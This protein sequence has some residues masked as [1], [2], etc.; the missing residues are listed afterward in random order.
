MS[1]PSFPEPPTQIP[2]TSAEEVERI[3]ERL[4]SRKAAWVATDIP[5]RIEYLRS[6]IEGVATVARDWVA[7]G[8]RN[9]GFSPDDVLAGE[10][11]LAGPVTTIR[12]ARLFM[13]ALAANGQPKVPHIERGPDGR[14]I[15]KVFPA[16]LRDRL[17][18][19][20]LSGEI[21]LEPGKEATQGAI[22][23]EKNKGEGKVGLVLGAGN[24]GSIAPMDALTKLFAENE[25]VIV[26]MNPVNAHV[27]PHLERAFKALIDDGFMAIVYGGADVGAQLANHPKVDTLHVTGSDKTYD[28]IVWGRDPAEAARRKAA[29]EPLNTRPF[30]AELGCVTPVLV[31]P[32]D[33]SS[34]DLDFHARNIVGMVT[35]NASFNCNAAKVMVLDASWP[36]R[37][38][39]IER[40]QH[41]MSV[42]APRKAYY[43]G[44]RDR[45]QRFI[46]NYPQSKV[47]GQDG[48]GIVPW[49]YIPSVPP[50]QGEYA[51]NN[52]AF[53]GVLAETSIEGGGPAGFMEKATRFANEQCWGT[54][55]IMVIAD[56]EAQRKHEDAFNAMIRDLRYG[57]IAI[58][59]WA[60]LIYG[61]VVT[62]W[63]AFPGHPPTDIRSG[64]GTV[65]NSYL[66]DHPERSVLRAPFRMNP[67]PVWF[68]DH[69]NLRALGEAMLGM[70]RSPSWMGLI[71]VATRALPG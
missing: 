15:A 6:V 40:V 2:P 1:S 68:A 44:A 57:G 65:H 48:E 3:V 69:K 14:L 36:L 22:Y 67:T 38:R 5:K 71:K 19:A 61:L 55:S 33:W 20:G 8:S 23:R 66:L 43:P 29:N 11:W 27:G 53:C 17:M 25:V 7:D 34:S 39:F 70:E 35:Q 47:L 30:T 21:W 63:G 41:H 56:N 16:D 54:L 50:V 13:E 46:D 62:T 12:N 28:A 59:C 10:E 37:E 60:G 45:W 58:N 26:K 32:G 52:E 51:L 64:A 49:T 42:A 24:V 31:V 4:A 18:F 9:K